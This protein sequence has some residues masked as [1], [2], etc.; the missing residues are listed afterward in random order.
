ML[1][2]PN[3]QEFVW[4]FFQTKKIIVTRLTLSLDWEIIVG[5][6]RETSRVML[7][8]TIRQTTEKRISKSWDI[9][10]SVE[11]SGSYQRHD[12]NHPHISTR[13]RA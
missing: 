1:M 10:W 11:R 4:V 5:E 6:T 12:F 7:Q 13:I 3:M 9:F 8:P 2:N